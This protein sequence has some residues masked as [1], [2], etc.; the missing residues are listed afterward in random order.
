[1]PERNLSWYLKGASGQANNKGEHN[2][3][4]GWGECSLTAPERG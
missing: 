4:H 2:Q 3:P 1:M